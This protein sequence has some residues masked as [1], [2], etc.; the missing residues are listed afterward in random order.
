MTNKRQVK[1]Y[2]R[3]VCGDLAA[4]LL[5][6][7]TVYA[8]F[9]D[10]EVTAIINEIA[11]LQVNALAAVSYSYDKVAKD[12]ELRSQYKRERRKYNH[13]A[14]KS[15]LANFTEKEREIVKKMNA[16]MPQSVKDSNK[17]N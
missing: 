7:R 4:E 17:K 8:G 13:E 10:K 6:A 15:L 2:I 14:M 12:Y 1:K 3:N 5:I 16:A 11:E 9:D